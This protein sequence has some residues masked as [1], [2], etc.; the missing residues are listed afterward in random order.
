MALTRLHARDFRCFDVVEVVPHARIN[1]II[2]TNGAG[3]TSLLEAIYLVGRGRSFRTS[4]LVALRRSGS[5]FFELGAQVEWGP[6][7]SSV[8]IRGGNGGL[9]VQIEDREAKGLAG[10]AELLPVQVIE[11]G[12]HK[13]VEE[14]PARRRQFLDWGVFHVEPRLL[15]T[16]RRFQR[17]L[18]QRNAGLRE[19]AS[20]RMLAG[21]ESA[22]AEAGESLHRMRVEHVDRLR[23]RLASA[24]QD[25][26]NEPVACEYLAGWDPELSLEEA[27]ARSRIRDRRRKATLCG[28]QRGDLQL[29]IGGQPARE[30]VSRGEQKLLSA[31]IILAQID[32]LEALSLPTG[33]LLVDDPAAELDDG[34]LDR[35][36]RALV[37]R[38]TQLFVTALPDGVPVLPGDPR[39]F[40]VEQGRIAEM[41]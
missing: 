28:P 29:E 9:D 31:A 18:R 23:P 38:Q 5:G 8:R 4:N 36:V 15:D 25:L 26:L 1:L 7:R 35:L 34:R 22:L 27:L 19:E 12:A 3:K 16:W 6:H 32:V 10:L 40:H 30:R 17:A 2:G 20:D 24:A 14:G 39:V 33:V 41:L 11:P 37:A 13:L 21:F